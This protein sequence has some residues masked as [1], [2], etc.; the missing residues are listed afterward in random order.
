M[1]GLVGEGS[2]MSGG[3]PAHDTLNPLKRGFTQRATS[4]VKPRLNIVSLL[5][6]LLS[7]LLRSK[8]KI[9]FFFFNF[10]YSCGNGNY[11]VRAPNFW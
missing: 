10:T 6:F 2:A 1:N 3:Y 7:R 11:C 9:F 8:R 4:I 5:T